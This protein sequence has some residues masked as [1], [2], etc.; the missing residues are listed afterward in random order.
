MKKIIALILTLNI[1]LFYL[2]L[3]IYASIDTGNESSLDSEPSGCLPTRPTQEIELPILL[4]DNSTIQ[5]RGSIATIGV[6]RTFSL[7]LQNQSGTCSA[8]AKI[9]FTGSYDIETVGTT[10]KV[11]NVNIQYSIQGVQNWDISVNSVWHQTGSTNV[12]MYVYYG[13]NAS[14]IYD[15][16]VGGGYF[17][18]TKTFTV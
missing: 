10:K 5:T 8:T 1:C 2:P 12:T 14:N 11:T 17:Y 15:C 6:D 9:R 3:N 4:S 18:T 16:V 13:S 7:P